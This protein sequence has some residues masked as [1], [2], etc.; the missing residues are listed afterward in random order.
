MFSVGG[1][2]TKRASASPR[3]PPA[4]TA[5]PAV[6]AIPPLAQGFLVAFAIIGLVAS[7]AATWVHY[8]L[9]RNP[10]YSAFC[11]ISATVSCRDAYLSQYGSIGGVP[12]AVAGLFF[13]VF[14]LLLLWAGRARSRTAE[15]VPA[16]LLIFSTVALGFVLYLAYASFFVLKQACPL[17]IGTYI[18]VIGLFLLSAR[19]ATVPL[20]RVPAR[21]MQDVGAAAMSPL[22][23]ALT[24]IFVGGAVAV[25]ASFPR[26]AERPA[27]APLV[28]LPQDQRAELARWFDLQPKV[29]LPF[30]AGG[31]KVVVV[32]FN[33][34]QCPP[35]KAT[36][37]GYEPVVAKYKDRPNDVRFLL[38]HFPLERRLVLERNQSRKDADAAR[39]N[40]EVVVAAAIPLPSIFDHL[41]P[42]AIGAI[43]GR[44]LFEPDDAVR[45]AMH[46]A[47]VRF[48]RKI[49]QHE[50]GGAA[51]SEIMLQRKNL[52]PISQR[53][54][55]KEADLG[56]AIEN[57]TCR[58]DLL[59]CLE[60]ALGCLA[61]LKVGRIKKALLL[62]LVEKALRR[63][64]LEDVDPF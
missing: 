7:V 29:D 25:I 14:V 1:L 3:K 42:A 62:L 11:D 39:G 31:A 49:V 26:P 61:K 28:P 8:Q 24:V 34:F 45:D 37:F 5:A 10:D 60:D 35:C 16:Y 40:D 58:A 17:C 38:K 19:F 32:K 44:K 27:V 56:K 63:H 9:L 6:P 50:H 41:Q 20:S 43:F 30:D 2:L 4:A 18:A 59:E 13:F 33:D 36:Y 54:L 12:V 47:V 55:R 64:E 15:S 46:R 22:A 52:T 53:R 51:A 23:L 57:H 48:A 21:A